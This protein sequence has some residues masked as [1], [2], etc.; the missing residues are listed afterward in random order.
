MVRLKSH[1][2]LVIIIAVATFVI[3]K[4]SYRRDYPNQQQKPKKD[5]K[6]IVT[7]KGLGEI[8]VHENRL[9]YLRNMCK[10]IYLDWSLMKKVDSKIPTQFIVDETD[11]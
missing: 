6:N 8:I 1:F 3:L 7:P 2:V 4:S 11:S 10:K 9:E 5:F